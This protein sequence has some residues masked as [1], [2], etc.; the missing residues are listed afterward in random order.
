MSSLSPLGFGVTGPHVTPLVARKDTER[1]VRAAID[2]GVTTFDTGPMYGDGEG[3]VRLGHA[4]KGVPRDSVFVITKARAWGGA[5]DAPSLARSLEDSLRRLQLDHV[6]AL[7]LH[8]PGADDVARA[9]A[10]GALHALRDRGLA[11][12]IGVCG[13]GSERAAML[14]CAGDLF[15]LLMTPLDDD[16]LLHRAATKNVDVI[17]IETMRSRRRLRALQSLA[18]VWY[19]A[20]DARDAL[21]GAPHPQGPGL[22]AA[23][24]LPGVRSAIV[25]T[26]RR[27]HLED[28]ARLAAILPTG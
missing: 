3:E 19:L 5:G 28:N 14:D 2:L 11:P 20:R 13:R 10:D 24:A 15:D 7:L 18:D 16:A 12:R 26:T 8:G 23:L 27:A 17:A 6:D 22:Q 4:L 25:T 9:H 21:T 1:L